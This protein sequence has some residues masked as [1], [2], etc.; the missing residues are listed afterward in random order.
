MAAPLLRCGD[1]RPLPPRS[2]RLFALDLS[3][4]EGRASA[5]QAEVSRALERWYTPEKRPFW[6]HIT[7]A[8]VKRASRRVAGLPESPAAP[9]AAFRAGTLTLYRS[10]LRPQGALYEPLA[11]SRAALASAACTRRW[12]ARCCSGSIRSGRTT[13]RCAAPSWPGAWARRAVRP[14]APSGWRTR[15]CGSSSA[16]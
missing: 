11:R 2:P 13:W 16:A 7:L 6:P 12:S 8:R 9:Q 4:E 5:L 10:T 15:G 3:D 1:V 14:G